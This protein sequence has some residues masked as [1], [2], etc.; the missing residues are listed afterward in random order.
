LDE[1]ISTNNPL[2][3][4]G[5]LG[6]LCTFLE[7][8]EESDA[9]ATAMLPY[10]RAVM[11]AR[12]CEGH[13]SRWFVYK[14]FE[15]L[16]SARGWCMV[17]DQVFAARDRQ[18][19]GTKIACFTRYGME[20]LRARSSVLTDFIATGSKTL[21]HGII[22]DLQLDAAVVDMT[23]IQIKGRDDVWI[24]CDE[25]DED[26]MHD[27]VSCCGSAS[28]TPP[29]HRI[30]RTCLEGCVDGDVETTLPALQLV[31]ASLLVPPCV[32][33]HEWRLVVVASGPLTVPHV[34]EKICSKLV[35]LGVS[36]DPT[37]VSTRADQPYVLYIP[38]WS[39]DMVDT[40]ESAVTRGNVVVV[41]S[42]SGVPNEI[43]TNHKLRLCT[44]HID[45]ATGEIKDE[46]AWDKTCATF[47][48]R[49]IDAYN[50]DA[51]R[52][53]VK[54]VPFV[55]PLA[56][57]PYRVVPHAAVAC[58]GLLSEMLHGCVGA[59]VCPGTRCTLEELQASFKTYSNG[60]GFTHLS[61]DVGTVLKAAEL[62][63]Y[64]T[65]DAVEF[66]VVDRVF[67]NICV[68]TC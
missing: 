8:L 43:C 33:R 61:L 23:H 47:L 39:A 10:V 67:K 11:T 50:A 56:M 35:E 28:V 45:G 30:P 55:D 22:D 4:F 14:C 20:E 41:R 32:R 17:G 60:R 54:R 13:A 57:V 25:R 48:R 26:D 1:T 58:M 27:S 59:R 31:F 2:A 62:V 38:Q 7:P 68:D 65:A 6:D 64:T 53:S 63:K 15:A 49:C 51:Q 21:L 18:K 29:S 16:A 37:C 19:L 24:A 52:V 12:R 9:Y 5:H 36:M 44:V 3:A 46:E 40:V 42:T 66:C 34:I